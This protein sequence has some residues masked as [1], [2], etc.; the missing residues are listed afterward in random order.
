[1]LLAIMGC[2]GRRHD[3][4]PTLLKH[5]FRRAADL[6]CLPSLPLRGEDADVAVHT[7]LPDAHVE[8]PTAGSVILAPSC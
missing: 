7:W 2:T 5:G 1:M 4:I 8:A 6:A 3:D